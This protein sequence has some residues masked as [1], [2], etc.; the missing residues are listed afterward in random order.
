MTEAER[1]LWQALRL[2][3]FDGYKFRRQHPLGDCVVDFVCIEARLVVE[4]DGWQHNERQD[5]DAL[6]T[7][8]LRQRGYRV[9]RFWNH[10]VMNDIEAVKAAIWEALHGEPQPPS[11]PS[12]CQG[13]GAKQEL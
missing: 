9:V 3:Q 12:P 1:R 13:E 8:Q 6:R 4:V 5:Y 11:Q 7:D 10:E 2:R